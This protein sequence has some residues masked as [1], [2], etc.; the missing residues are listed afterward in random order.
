MKHKLFL[1]LI[2]LIFASLACQVGSPPV[3]TEATVAAAIQAT[4]DAEPTATLTPSPSPTD[5]P[6][7][8]ETPTPTETPAPTDT[9]TVTPLPTGAVTSE[10]AIEGWTRYDFWADGFSVSLPNSWQ[11]ITTDPETMQNIMDAAGENNE[12]VAAMFS[13]QYIQ[14]LVAQGVKILAIDTDPKS[15]SGDVVTNFNL[16]AS[17]LPYEI[18]LDTLVEVTVSQLGKIFTFVEPMQ[19][20]RV[21]LGP[22]QLEAERFS[23]A[24]EQVTALGT[25]VTTRLV[26]YILVDGKTEYALTFTGEF[27]SAEAPLPVFEDIAQT[28]EFLKP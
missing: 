6:L 18:D 22:Q 2:V 3:D 16:L 11:S 9:P 15:L 21:A 13:S 4:K 24:I 12:N 17:D 28:L 20:E 14:T 19:H 7:P 5:T 27:E 8:T 26:Q 1:P 25:T 23:Y 10:A